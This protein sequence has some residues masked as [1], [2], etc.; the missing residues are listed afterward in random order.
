MAAL[1]D[2]IRL[3]SPTGGAGLADAL[4]SSLRAQAGA[5]DERGSI[6]ARLADAITRAGQPTEFTDPQDPEPIG[7]GKRLGLGLA[8][9]LTTLGRGFNPAIQSKDFLGALRA[10][11]ERRAEI[12]NRRSER[13]DISDAEAKRSAARTEAQVAAGELGR[14]DRMAE[15]EASRRAATAAQTRGIAAQSA[16]DRAMIAS[17]ERMSAAARASDEKV[18]LG[19][20]TQAQKNAQDQQ[21]TLVKQ[22]ILAVKRNLPEELKNKSRGQVVRDTLEDIEAS[23]LTED[24]K[25]QAEEFVMQFLIPALAPPPGPGD[26]DEGLAFG[27]GQSSRGALES[28]LGAGAEAGGISFVGGLPSFDPSDAGLV[29]IERFLEGFARSK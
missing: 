18:K 15:A 7:L 16:R 27:A 1:D 26:T 8:S 25:K 21:L 23:G 2:I 5:A 11:R 29:A 9:G 10:L 14:L 13:R 6:E 28:I 17:R 3:L 4:Q 22:A 12:A 24:H 20:L 19:Q